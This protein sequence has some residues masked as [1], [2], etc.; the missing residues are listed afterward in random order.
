MASLR[1]KPVPWLRVPD[2]VK[3]VRCPYAQR[4]HPT[5]VGFPHTSQGRY[6]FRARGGD[7]VDVTSLSHTGDLLGVVE[8]LR[9]GMLSPEFL[10]T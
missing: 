5:I 9:V 1:N 4:I 6:F 2:G 8:L 10:V 7:P 3:T